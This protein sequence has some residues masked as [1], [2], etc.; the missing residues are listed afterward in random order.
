VRH[1][2]DWVLRLGDGTEES[3]NRMQQSFDSIWEFTGDL[4]VQNEVDQWAIANGIG[5]DLSVLH[6]TWKAKVA[7]VLTEATLKVPSDGWMQHVSKTGTHTEHMG[8][9]LTELQYVQR[10]YPGCE[11]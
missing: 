10:A 2:S 6:Q 8:F 1:S 4:F 7:Q 3:H 5:P 11:W 9:I